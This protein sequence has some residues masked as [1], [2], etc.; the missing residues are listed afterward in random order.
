MIFTPTR[1]VTPLFHLLPDA[2]LRRSRLISLDM[3]L[4]MSLDITTP[5]KPDQKFATTEANLYPV[6]TALL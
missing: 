5:N 6:V 3:S 2:A 4:G 1:R